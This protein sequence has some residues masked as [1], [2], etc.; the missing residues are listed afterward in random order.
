[1]CRGRESSSSVA[2]KGKSGNWRQFS[3]ALVNKTGE[4]IRPDG[5]RLPVRISSAP[6]PGE[7]GRVVVLVQ[8][9]SE[10]REAEF[11]RALLMREVDHRAKNALAIVQAAIR[12]APKED[13]VAY[14]EAIEGRV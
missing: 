12:L 4:Y 1:M 9:I 8:D 14:A 7:P 6:L 10:Q 2:N 5:T 3:P 11:R 13:A